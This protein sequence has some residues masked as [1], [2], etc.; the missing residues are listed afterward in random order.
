MRIEE[1]FFKKFKNIK[2]AKENEGY[3]EWRNDVEINLKGL[4]KHNLVN[5]E[6]RVYLLLQECIKWR[7]SPKVSGNMVNIW[8]LV[9]TII[10]GIVTSVFEKVSIGEMRIFVNALMVT[11]FMLVIYFGYVF[12]SDMFSY[13]KSISKEL[14]YTELL[15][16]IRSIIAEQDKN[17]KTIS[18]IND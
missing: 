7:S 13:K 8:M 3:I 11:A 1:S 2:K 4:E 15:E 16:V 12:I 9:L 5:M 14:Y 17:I 18:T 10:M 6:K